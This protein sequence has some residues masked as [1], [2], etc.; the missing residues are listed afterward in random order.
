MGKGQVRYIGCFVSNSWNYRHAKDKSGKS[1]RAIIFHLVPLEEGLAPALSSHSEAS[2]LP[3]NLQALDELRRKALAS[4]SDAVESSPRNAKRLYYERSE[5]IRTYV[6]KRAGAVCE[7]CEKVA[8]FHR[9]DGSPYLEPHHTR[10][11]SDGGPDHPR[12]VG[13]VCPNCHRE[14]HYGVKGKPLNRR[15]EERLG[16][17][18]PDK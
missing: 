11:L 1:R 17:I 7:A 8:P 3:L 2:Q 13:A 18:E 14:I 16:A 4:A 6:L 10:R 12:W 15:L 9:K 5:A